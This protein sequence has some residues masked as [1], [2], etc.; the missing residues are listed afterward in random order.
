MYFKISKLISQ[1]KREKLSMK[2]FVLFSKTGHPYL[3]RMVKSNGGGGEGRGDGGLAAVTN[4][5]VCRKL[6]DMSRV[7]S[8]IYM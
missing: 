2:Q 3:E 7:T 8:Y 1:K 6:I 4:E 5:P